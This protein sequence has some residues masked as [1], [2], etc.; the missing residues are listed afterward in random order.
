MQDLQL[1]NA[2]RPELKRIIQ[3]SVDPAQF[4]KITCQLEAF[5]RMNVMVLEAYLSLCHLATHHV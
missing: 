3:N 2:I 5:N 4:A 1:R